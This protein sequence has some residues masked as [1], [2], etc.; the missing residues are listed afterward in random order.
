[1]GKNV[2]QSV[3]YEVVGGR[4]AECP[5]SSWDNVHRCVFDAVGKNV[6]QN[7]LDEVGGKGLAEYPTCMQWGTTTFSNV[8]QVHREE[9]SAEY[10]LDAVRY[11][12]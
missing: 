5:I 3:L 7:V 11:D 10:P 1:V 6:Q 12:F 8:S 9:Y 2:Q 4:S